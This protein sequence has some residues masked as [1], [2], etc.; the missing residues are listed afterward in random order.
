MSKKLTLIMYDS[1][2]EWAKIYAYK[3][4]RSLSTIVENYLNTLLQKRMI[5]KLKKISQDFQ[6]KSTSRKIL[7]KT[8][9]LVNI[10]KKAFLISVITSKQP[11]HSPN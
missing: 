11:N 5:L 2:I 1:I 8:K 4:N 3:T 9:D 7:M 6:A 10:W